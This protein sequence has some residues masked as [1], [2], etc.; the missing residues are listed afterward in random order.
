M[1][2]LIQ[3][4]PV[5]MKRLGFFSAICFLLLGMI[6]LCEQHMKKGLYD[7]QM[8]QRWAA[9][10]GAAQISAF[11]SE[12]AVEDEN[13]FKGIGQSVENALQTA[14]IVK[15]NENAR[16]WIDAVSK[17]G[18]VVLTTSRGN[19]EI[20]ALGVSG[21]FFQF[22]PQKLLYGSLFSQDSMMQDGIVIDEDIAWQLFGSSNV[23]GMQVMI[24]QVPHFITGV[25]ERADGRLERAAGLE[26]PVC[27][28]SLESL[29]KYGQVTSGF[30]YEIVMP[31]PIKNYA[32]T[33]M[34]TAIGAENENVILIENS[35]RFNM[36]PLLGIIRD[37]GIRSMSFKDVVYPYWENIARGQ[38]DILALLLLL[39]CI[40]LILPSIFIIT[41]IIYLWKNRTWHLKQGVVW[42]QDKI[43]EAGTKRVQKKE[44]EK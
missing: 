4:I 20:N 7:Q 41:I 33:T 42:I 14:S 15:E 11:Y 12:D 1:K 39:K 16:L 25:I 3:N 29:Q 21:E 13:Y 17:N 43:Y 9:D 2:N 37:F 28:M 8:A 26:K 27:Y 36:L 5:R 19:I 31:N 6:F 18:K 32:Y 10:G 38:E 24:G 35:T 40:L 23:A 44:M 22:H 30:T 34:Q